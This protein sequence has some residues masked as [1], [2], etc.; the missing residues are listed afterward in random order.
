MNI[1]SFYQKRAD[2]TCTAIAYCIDALE[3]HRACKCCTDISPVEIFPVDKGSLC[4]IVTYSVLDTYF[5]LQLRSIALMCGPDD[6]TPTNTRN[7]SSMS[8]IVFEPWIVWAISSQ[9]IYDPLGFQ[10]NFIRSL[11][12]ILLTYRVEDS[13]RYIKQE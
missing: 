11:L 7:V 13:S 1:L 3:S 2:L 8:D 9:I 4:Y 10:E 12:L 6:V 5:P